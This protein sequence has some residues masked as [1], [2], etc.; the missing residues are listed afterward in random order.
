ML[1][2]GAGRGEV[3]QGGV[4]DW[5]FILPLAFGVK[6]MRC[7]VRDFK[8]LL[9]EKREQKCERPKIPCTNVYTAQTGQFV[10]HP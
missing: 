3:G 1:C 7:Y 4:D 2:G 6:I 8:S 5:V 10:M 9:D